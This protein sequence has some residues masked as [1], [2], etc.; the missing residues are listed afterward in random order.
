MPR[1]HRASSSHRFPN[2]AFLPSLI[3]L[4]RE[5]KIRSKLLSRFSTPSSWVWSSCPSF[6]SVS[7][8]IVQCQ[9][10]SFHRS[11]LGGLTVEVLAVKNLAPIIYRIVS[12]PWH[13]FFFQSKILWISK[14][15]FWH[16]FKVNGLWKKYFEKN[17]FF[18]QRPKIVQVK[19]DCAAARKNIWPESHFSK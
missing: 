10:T 3:L 14:F 12:S 17:T 11:S 15:A 13:T 7:S 6:C 5:A 9:L 18:S 1:F 19:G 4:H 16:F 8:F 2:Q